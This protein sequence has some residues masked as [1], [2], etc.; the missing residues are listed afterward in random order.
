MNEPNRQADI[1][2]LADVMSRTM[3]SPTHSTELEQD[4]CASIA[5][6][7]QDYAA[8]RGVDVKLPKDVEPYPNSTSPASP[9]RE[10]E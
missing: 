9:D 8:K 6:W 7:V 4:E 1:A 3:A 5:R 10:T 2:R